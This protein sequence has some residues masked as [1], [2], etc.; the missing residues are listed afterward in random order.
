MSVEARLKS[1]QCDQLIIT[2][3]SFD[4]KKTPSQ[5]FSCYFFKE[6]LEYDHNI[7]I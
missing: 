6:S 2:G 7:M 5:S 3:T 1:T 4:Q